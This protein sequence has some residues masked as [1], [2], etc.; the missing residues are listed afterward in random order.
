[1]VVPKDFKNWNAASETHAP[2]V[3][4]TGDGGGWR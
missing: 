2:W 4:G 1:V 3:V